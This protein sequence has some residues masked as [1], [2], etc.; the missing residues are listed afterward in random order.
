MYKEEPHKILLE[1]GSRC[2][3]SGKWYSSNVREL[4]FWLSRYSLAFK[5]KVILS[6]PISGLSDATPVSIMDMGHEE[7]LLHLD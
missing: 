2:A 4:L 7:D 6:S 3:S 5:P 1:I